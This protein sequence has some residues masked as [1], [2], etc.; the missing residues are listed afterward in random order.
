MCISEKSLASSSL[1]FAINQLKMA[2]TCPS[3]LIFRLSTPIPPSFSFSVMC[4]SPPSY[5]PS[6]GLTPVLSVSYYKSPNWTRHCRCCL[7][8][9]RTVG[10][11][12]LKPLAPVLLNSAQYA[13]GI[14]SCKGALGMFDMLSTRTAQSIFHHISAQ[15]T[16]LPY[17]QDMKTLYLLST[18][19]FNVIL[20]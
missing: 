8:K 7:P 15:P 14:H 20:H 3:S 16:L 18:R 12:F 9:N 19:T 4:S 1:Y 13:V 6:T 11:T 10:N 2:V 5:W 17:I